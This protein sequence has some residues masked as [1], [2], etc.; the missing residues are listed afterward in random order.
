M[1]GTLVQNVK[2]DW[3]NCIERMEYTNPERVITTSRF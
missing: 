3:L 2:Q 1:L